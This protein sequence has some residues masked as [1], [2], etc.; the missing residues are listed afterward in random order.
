MTT[1]R[2]TF[3]VSGTEARAMWEEVKANQSRLDGCPAHRFDMG[4]VVMLGQRIKC[5]AC[6]GIMSLTDA[7]MYVRG[8]K[9]AGGDPNN[10]WPGFE[11]RLCR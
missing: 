10:V 1:I 8:Y 2:K 9:A 6:G 3:R 5:E 11:G 4:E 7:T